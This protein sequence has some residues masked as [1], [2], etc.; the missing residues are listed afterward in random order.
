MRIS[1]IDIEIVIEKGM[2]FSG[3]SVSKDIGLCASRIMNL[4]CEIE[5]EGMGNSVSIATLVFEGVNVIRSVM[6]F[7]ATTATYAMGYFCWTLADTKSQRF[8]PEIAN[9]MYSMISY[10]DHLESGNKRRYKQGV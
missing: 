2:I 1:E 3:G 4:L 9:E 5:M 7:D 10:F 6:G 8:T